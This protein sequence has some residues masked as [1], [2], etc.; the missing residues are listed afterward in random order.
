M[1]Q[2]GKCVTLNE[3]MFS[4]SHDV[5]YYVVTKHAWVKGPFKEQNRAMGTVAASL[6]Q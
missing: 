1:S 2:P 4:N 3:Q 6:A 5:I